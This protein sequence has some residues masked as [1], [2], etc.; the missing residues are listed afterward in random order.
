MSHIIHL[1]N[2]QHSECL[3]GKVWV[4]FKVSFQETQEK[5]KLVNIKEKTS[6]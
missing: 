6:S 4:F 5:P 1:E 3:L 2:K